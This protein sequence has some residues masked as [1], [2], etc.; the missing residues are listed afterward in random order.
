MHH[1]IRFITSLIVVVLTLSTPALAE[2][3][4]QTP[5]HLTESQSTITAAQE[6]ELTPDEWLRYQQLKNGR[7]GV[8][9]PGLDPLTM[10]GTEARSDEERRRL[11]ELWVKQE[12]QRT[13]AEL[14][15]QREVDNA[16]RRIFPRLLP[17]RHNPMA[18]GR[19][20]L[21]VRENCPKCDQ[22]LTQLLAT[23]QPLDI[24]L[25]G[26]GGQDSAVRRWAQKQRIPAAKVAS[27]HITLNHDNGQW[28]KYS[29]GKMPVLL[30]QEGQGWSHVN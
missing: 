29:G 5:S 26:S 3:T 19:R 1:Q 25:V 6:W 14:A 4:L 24:Y 15:F 17:V 22:R 12:F 2:N 20:A 9:S 16:W 30:Q 8:L 7:R 21:F 18:T 28:L 27:R 11:A 23:G 10:L 13:E